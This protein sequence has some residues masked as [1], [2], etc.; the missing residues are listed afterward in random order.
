MN[1]ALVLLDMQ[2]GIL[3][4]ETIRWEDA[5]APDGA[6][7]AAQRLIQAFR[8][9]HVPVMQVGVARQKIRGTF[10]VP[11]STAA[12]RS[13]RPP[14]DILPLQPGTA[15]TEFVIA[16]QPEDE[17]IHKIGVSAFQGTPLDQ[18]LR[19]AGAK[20]VII[21]GTFTHMAVESTV[22][23][24]FDLGYH[25]IVAKDAC[26]APAPSLHDHALSATL[27]NF[28]R[29]LSCDDIIAGLTPVAPEKGEA[30]ADKPA[31][32]RSGPGR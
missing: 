11:R 7:S 31:E 19:N 12:D 22:R 18:M 14:R 1:K 4:S 5:N 15:E 13:G 25:I 27:P 8:A 30:P 2:K 6:I 17:V 23:Q 29:I 10:D 3:Y 16:P 26:C 9:A 24:G 28:A 21:A 20:E 32:G